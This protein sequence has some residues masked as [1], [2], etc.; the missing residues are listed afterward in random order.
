MEEYRLLE[1][2]EII[3]NGDEYR[4]MNR[5]DMRWT[6]CEISEGLLA[7]EGRWRRKFNS[8]SSQKGNHING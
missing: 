4:D 7:A 8:T 2:N 5:I 1:K 3:K 6:K